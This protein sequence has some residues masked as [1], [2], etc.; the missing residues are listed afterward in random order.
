MRPPCARRQSSSHDSRRELPDPLPECIR[1]EFIL[2]MRSGLFTRD[3]EK[4]VSMMFL[5]LDVQ[6]NKY[7]SER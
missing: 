3:W 2:E 6:L 7:E 1:S 4:I 5:S